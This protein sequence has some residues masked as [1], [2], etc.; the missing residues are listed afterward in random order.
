MGHAATILARCDC[1]HFAVEGLVDDAVACMLTATLGLLP[2]AVSL[3]QVFGQKLEEFVGVLFLGRHEILKRLLLRDPEARQNVGGRI[4]VCAFQRIEVLEHVV[5]GAAEAVGD[6]TLAALM[7]VAQIE[8]AQERIVE[9][10]LQHDILVAGCSCVVYAAKAIRS[11]RCD[12]RVGGDE[13]RVFFDLVCEQFVV[14]S[15]S[16]H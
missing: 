1:L 8:V 16:V 7:A 14:L 3:V 6:G 4:A 9:E 2:I 11:A 12:G 13:A 15:F 10:A 5:H